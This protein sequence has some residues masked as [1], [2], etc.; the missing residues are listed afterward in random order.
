MFGTIT[1]ALGACRDAD[2]FSV[3]DQ[4]KRLSPH[5]VRWPFL[6]QGC[7]PQHCC[8]RKII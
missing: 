7:R 3:P 1:S 6:A 5:G 2:A 4:L 8:E